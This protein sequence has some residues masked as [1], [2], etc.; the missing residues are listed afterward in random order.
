MEAREHPASYSNAF[1]QR[2]PRSSDP[3]DL[4]AA[5]GVFQEGW[6]I[7]WNSELLMESATHA[8]SLLLGVDYTI[9][10]PQRGGNSHFRKE[11]R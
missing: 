2:T 11:I 3:L 6:V 8:V 9:G 1:F 5:G 7:S 10:I 4:A